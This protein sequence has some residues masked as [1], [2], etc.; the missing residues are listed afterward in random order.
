MNFHKSYKASDCFD[1]KKVISRHVKVVRILEFH[2]HIFWN[3][4][5]DPVVSNRYRYRKYQKLEFAVWYV[6]RATHCTEVR[7]AS[8]LSGGFI[9]AMIIVNPPERKVVK[10]TSVHCIAG[11]TNAKNAL[12]YFK[13]IDIYT[14]TKIHP[15]MEK[16]LCLRKPFSSCFYPSDQSR[17]LVDEYFSLQCEFQYIIPA[18]KVHIF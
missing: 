13:C 4:L 1:K 8:F 2:N 5:L 14:Y 3:W 10:R 12:K 6:V 17:N 11:L 18:F 9:T 16:V 7:F 15:Y